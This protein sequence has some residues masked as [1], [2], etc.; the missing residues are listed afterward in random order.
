MVIFFPVRLDLNRAKNPSRRVS[1]SESISVSED[2]SESVTTSLVSS[3]SAS[4]LLRQENKPPPSFEPRR[5]R[6]QPRPIALESKGTTMPRMIPAKATIQ[7]CFLSD[8]A[9][10]MNLTLWFCLNLRIFRSLAN[11]ERCVR[12]HQTKMIESQI[13]PS[14]AS[15]YQLTASVTS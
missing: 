5:E 2:S 4:D 14:F 8:D 15:S 3:A 6:N 7:I 1:L 11:D 10:M 9:I 12:R 13:E